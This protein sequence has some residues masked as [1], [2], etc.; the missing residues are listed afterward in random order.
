MAPGLPESSGAAAGP[1]SPPAPPRRVVAE[2][3]PRMD[4]LVLFWSD[5]VPHEVLPPRRRSRRA[6]SVWYLCPRL[7]DSQFVLGTP[8]PVGAQSSSEAASAVLASCQAANATVPA[9]LH[10][11]LLG[12]V[13]GGGATPP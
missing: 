7:G 12:E 2:V 10:E 3:L 9:R 11:W 4:T 5:A 6:I 1:C 13:A 8:L